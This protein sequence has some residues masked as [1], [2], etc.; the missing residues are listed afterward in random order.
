MNS[1]TPSGVKN[2]LFSQN[3][4][5]QCFSAIILLVVSGV[6]P[7]AAAADP[8]RDQM[9][10][11]VKGMLQTWETGDADQFATAFGDKLL[12]AYPGDRLNKEQLIEL[13]KSYQQDKKDIKIYFGRFLVNGDRFAMTY[14][15]AA[16]DR[17]SG[18]RQAVGTAASGRI[19][20]GK[21]V[22][23]KEFYDEHVAK[24]QAAHEIPLDEGHVTAYP[25]SLMLDP[26]LIN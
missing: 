25:Y 20:D 4:L 7:I 5:R 12:F 17:K 8:A 18:A 19:E 21:I 1:I 22:L 13:F 24:R 10:A 11:Q 23:Y 16:T 2:L 15:F 14:Q 26:K 9:E 3:R 6:L